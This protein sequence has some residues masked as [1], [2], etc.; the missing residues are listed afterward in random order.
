MFKFLE[1]I[2]VDGKYY[3]RFRCQECGKDHVVCPGEA[4]YCCLEML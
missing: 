3:E 4:P 1:A 2:E